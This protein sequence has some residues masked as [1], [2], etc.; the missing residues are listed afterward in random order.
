MTAHLVDLLVI[1]LKQVRHFSLILGSIQTRA[2][3]CLLIIDNVK[4]SINL[5]I[6][7]VLKISKVSKDKIQ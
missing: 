5:C 3:E 4:K 1:V 7:T 2:V 6:Y